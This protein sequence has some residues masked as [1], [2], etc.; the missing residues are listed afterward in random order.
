MKSKTKIRGQ[1][2]KNN[3]KKNFGGFFC[4]RVTCLQI[5]FTHL[6]FLHD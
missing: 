1:I 4:Y 3:F 2:L 5:F 6:Q